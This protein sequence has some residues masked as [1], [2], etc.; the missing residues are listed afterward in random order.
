M[1]GEMTITLDAATSTTTSIVTGAAT[2][3]YAMTVADGVTLVN[4][5]NST[6]TLSISATSSATL[7]T[8]TAGTGNITVVGGD[9]GDDIAVGTLATAGQ[10]FTGSVSDFVVTASSNAQNITTGVGSDTIDGG[11]GD[12]TISS[13]AG[14]DSI[15]GGTGNDTIDLGASDALSD[16][17]VWATGDGLDTITSFLQGTGG[18]VLKTSLST[19]GAAATVVSSS[20]ATTAITL[21]GTDEV[22]VLRTA[23]A[24]FANLAAV[25][26]RLEVGSESIAASDSYYV[27]WTA[28]T[29]GLT[30]I[31]LLTTDGTAGISTGDTLEDILVL[32]GTTNSTAI[33]TA[34][35][36]Q[37]A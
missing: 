23:D 26:T 11:A 3:N 20:D 2:G 13:G 35:F 7:A 22:L 6:G 10:T 36:A 30:H 25:H 8:V 34:N 29:G 31:S 4:G 32:T 17:L 12:D 14:S 19:A 27:V 5:A 28:T 21:V 37:V 18:D 16:T 15:T 1:S 24:T 33:T 9:A